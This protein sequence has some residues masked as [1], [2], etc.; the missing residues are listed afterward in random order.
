MVRIE[1]TIIVNQI[2][3]SFG[4]DKDVVPDIIA[5]ASANM[6]DK[7]SRTRVIGAA[8]ESAIKSSVNTDIFGTDSCH[9]FSLRFF[10]QLRSPDAIEVK[11]NRPVGKT[12]IRILAGAPRYFALNAELMFNQIIGTE[13]GI[14]S[15]TQRRSPG[16]RS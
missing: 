7:M 1:L 15:A 8:R 13:G 4:S 6:A 12:E 11:E 3:V 9:R 2:V 14:Q 5:N 10:A 16:A